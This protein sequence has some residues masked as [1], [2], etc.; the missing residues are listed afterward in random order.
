MACGIGSCPNTWVQFLH[1]RHNFGVQHGSRNHSWCIQQLQNVHYLRLSLFCLVL[2]E[3]TYVVNCCV[4]VVRMCVVCQDEAWGRLQGVHKKGSQFQIAARPLNA[5]PFETLADMQGVSSLF[6]Q[7]NKSTKVC[8]I[9]AFKEALLSF[10]QI[11]SS[12]FSQ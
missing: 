9:I 10:V 8:R 2:V 11:V 4:N 6:A 1:F 5:I 7:E 12:L 3:Y